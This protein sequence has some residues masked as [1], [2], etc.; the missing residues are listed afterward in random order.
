[1]K[2]EVSK[3]KQIIKKYDI[4][5]K[6]EKELIKWINKLSDIEY[7]NLLKL[8]IDPTEIT[9]DKQLL[10]NKELLNKEDYI[11][12]IQA[13]SRIKCPSDCI[14]LMNV[15]VKP[16][17]LNSKNYYLDLILLSKAKH[18][19]YCLWLIIAKS[20]LNNKHHIEDMN[21][22]ANA[23]ERLVAQVLS[24]VAIN[25]NSLESK[26]HRSDMLLISKCS[27][28][29]LQPTNKYPFYSVNNLA[30]N[31]VSLQ[32][33][34]HEE[35][36]KI[37]ATNKHSRGYLYELMTNPKVIYTENYRKEISRLNKASSISKARAIYYFIV[38]PQRTCS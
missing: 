9:F 5:F 4:S 34:F 3:I 17:F 1:M 6:N 32:D 33:P 27:Q 8:D 16:E 26:Y 23:Q 30:V 12:R 31:K 11:L 10:I 38:S 7:N 20:Y 35:N 13:M 29:V 18:I 2:K 14:H 21:L 19:R 37:L 22:V 28:S 24:E 25:H 15:L 36:M